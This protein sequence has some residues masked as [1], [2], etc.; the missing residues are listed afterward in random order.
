MPLSAF[1]LILLAGVIHA[2]WNIA[3]K[4]ANGDSRFAFQSGVFMAVVWAPVGITL[5]W[6][7]VPTWGTKEWAFIVLSGVLHVFYYVVLLRGYRKSD[8]TVVYPLARGSGPLLSSLVAI[9]FLGEKIS[10]VGVAGIFGVVL[11]VFLVAG[12]PRLFH[13]KHDPVQRERV[14]KGMRYGVLT[15]A[16]IAA[17]TVTDSYAVKFLAMS[18]ILLDYMSNFVRLVLLLPAALQDRA[19]TVRMWR[20][21]WKYALLVAAI[22]PV[23]YVLVL[24]AVQQAPISHVAPAREVS[25]LF[26]ALIGG[27]LLREGDR[28]L[29]LLGALFIAA[30]VIALALG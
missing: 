15:G 10:L 26:A 11:G 19:T 22:S 25:M 14:H 23:S 27:H 2:S 29:R 5:G 24:Y 7:V 4:K 20:E 18:P 16:F 28:M 9:L 6:S 21:Q 30:G 17:Y 1:A 13:K 12:G 8:L 3:A